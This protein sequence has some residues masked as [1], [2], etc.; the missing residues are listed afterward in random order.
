MTTLIKKCLMQIGRCKEFASPH[1]ILQAYTQNKVRP[2]RNIDLILHSK[3]PRTGKTLYYRTLY[4]FS[5]VPYK[6]KI[7]HCL[8]LYQELSFNTR[9]Q[10]LQV[11]DSTVL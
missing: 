7:Y 4:F 9:Y 6:K 5:P 8:K 3:V 10:I 2:H 1:N 11:A